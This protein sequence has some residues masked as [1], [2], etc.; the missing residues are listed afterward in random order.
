M[1]KEEAMEVLGVCASIEMDG[2]ASAEKTFSKS[3]FT[4]A[5]YICDFLTNYPSV[6]LK[7]TPVPYIQ[8]V[9][10]EIS[11]QKEEINA[12]NINETGPVEKSIIG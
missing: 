12:Q 5:K 7:D 8:T 9:T 6:S 11:K 10:E 3:N 2:E 4:K 1:K